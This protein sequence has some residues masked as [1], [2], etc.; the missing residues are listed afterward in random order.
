MPP[1]ALTYPHV[2][3]CQKRIRAFFVGVCLI[4]TSR[5]KL[6]WLDNGHPV[7]AFT[8]EDLPSWYLT[9]ASE[10][11]EEIRFIIKL[12]PEDGREPSIVFYL[13]GPL[14]GLGFLKFD[15]VDAWFEEE[16]QIFV[17]PRDPYKRID[18]LQSSRHVRIEV[19]GIEIANT[20]CPIMLFETGH[21]MRTY[22]PKTH[23]RLD[24]WVPSGHQTTCPY[25]GVATHFNIVLSS[26]ETFENVMWSYTNTTSESANI[27]GLVAFLD[28]KV[29]VW[30]DGELQERPELP[31]TPQIVQKNTKQFAENF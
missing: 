7:Y 23:T 5:A 25:K 13:Q 4:D 8:R 14:I 28:E 6:V 18:V 12:G 17:H 24:L 22:I 16:E 9:I 29:D 15:A 3:D 2:E 1:I 27:K 19:N 20:R 26:G 21:P 30:I 10:S 31:S 11:P